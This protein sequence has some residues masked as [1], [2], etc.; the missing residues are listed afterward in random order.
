MRSRPGGCTKTKGDFIVWIGH[1]HNCYSV[2]WN[3]AKGLLD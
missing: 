3:I 2:D 1:A